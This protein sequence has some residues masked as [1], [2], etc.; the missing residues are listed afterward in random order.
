MVGETLNARAKFKNPLP[1]PLKKGRFL[2]EGP[3]LE[4]QLKL[5]LSETVDVDGDAEC[6]FSMV[7]KFEGR[8]TIAA[9]FYSKELEDVDG[10]INFMV[11]PAKVSSNGE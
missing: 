3:G 2:I 11:K 10:F 7:P 9:K 8:A 4:E 6:S 5:K 1:I